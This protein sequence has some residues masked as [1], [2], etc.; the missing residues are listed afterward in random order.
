[1]E[2]QRK[3]SLMGGK[4]EEEEEEEGRWC[5]V[6][7]GSGFSGPVST[8]RSFAGGWS[9]VLSQHLRMGSLKILSRVGGRDGVRVWWEGPRREGPRREG[10]M[11]VILGDLM[12]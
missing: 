4:E 6:V 8:F 9:P 7:F 10:W 2:I 1:M 12:D 11:A 3:D 5:S